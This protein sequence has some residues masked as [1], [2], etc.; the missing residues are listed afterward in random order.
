MRCYICD[1]P[2]DKIVIDQRDGKVKPCDGCLHEI[3]VAEYERALED[4]EQ[5]DVLTGLPS[6]N[7]DTQSG[8]RVLGLGTGV[9]VSSD[10]KG[11]RG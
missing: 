4:L 3:A 11:D 9:C 5:E 6:R 7:G 1:T 10:K 8:N 2:L